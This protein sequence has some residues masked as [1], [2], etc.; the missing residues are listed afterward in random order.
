MNS[1]AEGAQ[2]GRMT[3]KGNRSQVEGRHWGTGLGGCGV[4][5]YQHPKQ[6]FTDNLKAFY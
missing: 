2:E 4:Q 6:F 1:G 5:G 3:G